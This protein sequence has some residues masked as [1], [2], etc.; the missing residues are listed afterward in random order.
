LYIIILIILAF[1]FFVWRLGASPINNLTQTAPSE[2]LLRLSEELLYG[3]KTETSTDSIEKSLSSLS[4]ADLIQGLS[5]DKAKKAFWINIYNAWYQILAIRYKKTN[6]SIFTQ[7]IIPIAG[8]QFSLDD[9]EH[10][11]L[12][13]Y[14]WKLSMGYLP[15]FFPSKLIKQLAVSTI[16]YRIHFALNCGA[17]S[18]PPIAFYKY[19]NIEKQL[20][21]ATNSFLM[22]ETSID[23][24]K[25]I[26]TT[27]KLLY[28]FKGD[29]HGKKGAILL[30]SKVYVK[31]YSD[32]TLLYKTYN[33]DTRLGYFN[34]NEN[35]PSY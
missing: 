35:K 19:E 32:Y 12:R 13:K 3:I 31:D 28:W 15:Q 22:G 20:D 23:I 9:I 16:D 29:F 30:I 1:F 6:P 25:K 18:C 27:S 11:I 14:R 33:W 5:N 8:H 10:G 26:I 21:M 17:T 34:N 24:A 7:K 2:K 4:K